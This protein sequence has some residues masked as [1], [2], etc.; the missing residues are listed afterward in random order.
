MRISYVTSSHNGIASFRY[1]VESIGKELSERGHHVTVSPKADKEADAVIFSKH[2]T[3]N[4][5]SYMEFCKLRG[6]KAIFDIC[7]DHFRKAPLGDH[8]RR[9]AKSADIV[10]VNSVEMQKRVQEEAW[11]PSIVIPDPVLGTRRMYDE[12]KQLLLGWFGQSMNI[13][14]L[15]EAYPA[16]AQIPL[17]IAIPGRLE[18]PEYFNRPWI[19]WLQW[20]PEVIAEM[21]EVCSGFI[22]PYRQLKPAKSAN[23]VLEAIWAGCPVLTDPLPAVQEIPSGWRA[24]DPAL[25]VVRELEADWTE[26]MM[27]AQDWIQ[28]HYS[29]KAITDQWEAVLNG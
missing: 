12:S 23:R 8:Y 5:A 4:D 25:K 3:F 15:Y 29:V 18:P 26:E 21:A 2:W 1:R 11:V 24:L 22:L 7:D 20:H 19:Q 14:G 28:K 16:G 13:P 6:Q 9:M 27:A 10:T 17:L